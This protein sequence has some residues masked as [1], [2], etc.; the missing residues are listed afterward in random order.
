MLGLSFS[1]N[2]ATSGDICVGFTEGVVERR[3]IGFV[4]PITG[5]EWQKLQFGALG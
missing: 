4:E 5:V 1:Q 2:Q 3:T